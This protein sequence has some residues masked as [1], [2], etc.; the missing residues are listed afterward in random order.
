[1]RTRFRKPLLYPLSYGGRRTLC[2]AGR[3]HDDPAVPVTRSLLRSPGRRSAA[4][5]R[6]STTRS[7]SPVRAPLRGLSRA[8][9]TGRRRTVSARRLRAPAATEAASAAGSTRRQREMRDDLGAERLRERDANRERAPFAEG[10]SDA[11]SMSSGR[12]PTIDLADRRSSARPGRRARTERRQR[13]RD[14]AELDGRGSVARRLRRPRSRF[15]A[16]EPMKPATKRFA[17]SLVERLRRSTCCS[18]PSRMTATRSP[19][20]I[21]SVWSCVT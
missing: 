20:V 2:R 3:V 12:M 7:G 15:I 19:I 14:L 21:A 18:R 16:G 17:G 8:V 10:T 4:A 6:R 11:S 13:Q 1:M 9:S 5:R